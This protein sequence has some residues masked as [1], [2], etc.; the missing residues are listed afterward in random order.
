MRP[1]EIASNIK[2]ERESHVDP[3]R[4]H[5]VFLQSRYTWVHFLVILIVSLAFIAI[6]QRLPI[7][8]DLI[9][10]GFWSDIP[11][12]YLNGN[13]FVYPPWG[14]ILLLP[15][16]LV[17]AAGA[18]VLSVVTVGLLAYKRKW[19]FF[20][21]FIIV[22]SPYFMM[23]MTK[24]NMDVLTMVLSVLLW[25]ISTG[26]P[27]GP[28]GRG[29]SLS[30]M[31][32]KPQG[33]FLLILFLLWKSRKEWRQ[34]LASLAFASLI[35]IPISL[36]GSPPLVL[37][38][39]NNIN[40]PSPQYQFYWLINNISLTAKFGFWVALGILGLLL[41]LAFS[42]VRAGKIPWSDDLTIS[43][44]LQCSMYLSPYAS[45]QSFSSALAFIPS[46]PAFLSQWLV[47]IFGVLMFGV[48]DS[49][50]A[51]WTIP[52]GLFTLIFYVL[53]LNRKTRR[54]FGLSDVD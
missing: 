46:W 3:H 11:R 33:T 12:T 18:R 17:Q 14:L 26:K 50:I 13:N 42:L 5:Q 45:Q 39:L 47:F 41:V 20:Y 23:T 37:Q 44:L 43:S 51:L 27:W 15:Y 6:P 36:M 4:F 10:K 2:P 31:L 48:I 54:L 49:S 35:I 25:E 9:T 52:I 30:I 1:R 24:S 38:W 28:V 7:D 22:L 8:W 34:L 29:L 40:H 21:F 53:S 32:L 16:Y 19:P